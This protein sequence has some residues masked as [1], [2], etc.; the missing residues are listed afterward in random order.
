VVVDEAGA[1]VDLDRL[2]GDVDVDSRGEPLD[3]LA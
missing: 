2:A 3:L 1:A